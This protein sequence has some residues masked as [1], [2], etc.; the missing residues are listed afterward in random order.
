M[1]P[2]DD[3]APLLLFFLGLGFLQPPI[4]S[5]SDL[6]S[7]LHSLYLWGDLQRSKTYFFFFIFLLFFYRRSYKLSTMRLGFVSSLSVSSGVK[8]Q[9]SAVLDRMIW[10]FWT[11][12]WQVT[13]GGQS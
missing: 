3:R 13:R 9:L 1:L 2:L 4:R 8:G 7:Y 6:G 11:S 5:T 10:P 12:P